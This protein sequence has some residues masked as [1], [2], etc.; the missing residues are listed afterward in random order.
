MATPGCATFSVKRREPEL[1]PPAAETPHE[2]KPLSDIDDQEG[3]RFH[4]PVIE[5]Y[6]RRQGHGGDP[7]AAVRDALAR[8]LVHYYPLAGRLREV[9]GRKLV[10]DCTGDGVLF[11]EA[12]ADVT[13]R[14]LAGDT[15]LQP[16]FP[17]LDDVLFDVPGSGGVLNCPLLLVQV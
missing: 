8:A 10:V 4:I 14:Q 7:V 6:Q 16:P 5:F 17:Y 3:L 15:S 2:L 1:V 9:A 13:L 11:V 12:D